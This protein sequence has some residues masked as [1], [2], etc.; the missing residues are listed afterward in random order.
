MLS[1]G[2]SDHTTSN[3][4]CFGA[5]ALGASIL[6]RHFTDRKDRSWSRYYKFNGSNRV[7]R[8][9]YWSY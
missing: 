6:E 2:L 7:E 3:L 5:V 9:N 8:I 1:L 4:A